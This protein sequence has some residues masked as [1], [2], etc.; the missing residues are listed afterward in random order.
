MNIQYI[1][2]RACVVETPNW[3]GYTKTSTGPNQGT[4]QHK[5]VKASLSTIRTHGKVGG[6]QRAPGGGE[7]HRTRTFRLHQ[8]QDFLIFQPWSAE[9][10]P[11][12][13]FIK[14][15]A[16]RREH[17]HEHERATC[18]QKKT[19]SQSRSRASTGQRIDHDSG[20][21]FGQWSVG[22]QWALA[23]WQMWVF[24][25]GSRVQPS[26]SRLGSYISSLE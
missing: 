9:Y 20:S 18:S 10:Y 3:Q 24:T 14:L 8:E 15:E 4:R 22:G 5:G 12:S 7:K 23:Q 13:L 6:V 1:F 19:A 2:V 26:C 16:L 21:L 11:G 25:H 17:E